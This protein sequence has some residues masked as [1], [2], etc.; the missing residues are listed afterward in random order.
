[1]KPSF[2]LKTRF[3]IS[4][5]HFDDKEYNPVGCALRTSLC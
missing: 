3:L 1:M 4:N 5:S 2:F